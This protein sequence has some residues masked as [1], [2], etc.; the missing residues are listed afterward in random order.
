MLIFYDLFEDSPAE[1]RLKRVETIR[2]SKF[3]LPCSENVEEG[4]NKLKFY[5]PPFI[6]LPT[7]AKIVEFNNKGDDN[8]RKR[9]IK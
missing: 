6:F 4:K 2:N 1:E 5:M 8:E 7:H 3:I 9:K